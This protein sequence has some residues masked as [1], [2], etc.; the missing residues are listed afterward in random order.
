[1]ELVFVAHMLPFASSTY[2]EVL[3][4]RFC[5]FVGKCMEV[6]GNALK[7]GFSLFGGHHIH[8]ITGHGIGQENYPSV[9]G[10]SYGFSFCTGVDYFYLFKRFSPSI[11]THAAK[12]SSFWYFTERSLLNCI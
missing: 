9:R 10:F 5:S 11:F 7:I 4:N 8:Y 1:M 2:T 6:G 12:V 3:T